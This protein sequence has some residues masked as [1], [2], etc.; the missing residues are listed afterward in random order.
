M[1][2]TIPET[3]LS[4]PTPKPSPAPSR[5]YH[6]P[7][8]DRRT[9]S[10]GVQLLV[11]PVAKLPL[12]TVLAIVEAGASVEPHGQQGVAALTAR[13]LLEGAAGMDGA[14]LY[15]RFH[16]ALVLKTSGHGV[17]SNSKESR[18]EA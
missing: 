18:G 13:L 16:R 17:D 6:F 15:C 4:A 14:A 7:H 10:N 8:F 12:V 3:P 1:S 9:L 5:D 11:A 2:E